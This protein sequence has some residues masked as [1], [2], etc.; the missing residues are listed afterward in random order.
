MERYIAINFNEL[1]DMEDI[2]KQEISFW[3]LYKTKKTQYTTPPKFPLKTYQYTIRF[4]NASGEF[5]DI[6]KVDPET[7][8]YLVYKNGEGY[9]K[10]SLL[11]EAESKVIDFDQI[12]LKEG[13]EGRLLD[14]WE[15]D[16]DPLNLISPAP[17]KII[18]DFIFYLFC[19]LFF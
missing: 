2:E 18:S 10:V 11:E 16:D 5:M 19:L 6:R 7:L 4:A 12:F 15:R 1:F 3:L 13:V 9:K 14:K 8:C 17:S